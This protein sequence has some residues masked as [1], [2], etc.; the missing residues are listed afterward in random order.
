MTPCSLVDSD[1]R[2]GAAGDPM[3]PG[4]VRHKILR[5]L[6]SLPTMDDINMI[7]TLTMDIYPLICAL[8]S[9]VFMRFYIW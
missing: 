6:N 8:N 4:D 2:L 3:F 7:F 1:C 9:R 5:N